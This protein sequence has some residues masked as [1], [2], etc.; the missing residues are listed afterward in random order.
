M[1]IKIKVSDGKGNAFNVMMKCRF[2]FKSPS[3]LLTQKKK[4]KKTAVQHV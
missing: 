4:K 2:V 3:T 1:F